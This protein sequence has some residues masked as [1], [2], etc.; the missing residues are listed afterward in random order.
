MRAYEESKQ[1][2]WSHVSHNQNMDYDAFCQKK[3]RKVPPKCTEKLCT[4]IHTNG[5]VASDFLI[6]QLS[7]GYDYVNNNWSGLLLFPFW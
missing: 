5:G 1:F 3:N 2:T 4:H 6:T 7:R